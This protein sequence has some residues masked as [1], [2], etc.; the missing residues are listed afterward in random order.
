[1]IDVTIHGEISSEV[2]SGAS[3][4]LENLRPVLSISVYPSE[5]EEIKNIMSLKNYKKLEANVGNMFTF[6]PVT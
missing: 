2:I 5:I 1:M 6:C 4:T 3:Q